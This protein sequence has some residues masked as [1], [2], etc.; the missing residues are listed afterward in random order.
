MGVEYLCQ[1]ITLLYANFLKLA[2]VRL[3]G[4]IINNCLRFE[5]L[6]IC[7]Y[8][9][10]HNLYISIISID[11]T[12]IA[13]KPPKPAKI[14]HIPPSLLPH[15]L[16]HIP[17]HPH[18]TSTIL[19]IIHLS[20]HTHIHILDFRHNLIHP[21]DYFLFI[22]TYWLHFYYYPIRVLGVFADCYY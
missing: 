9:L 3:W 7:S 22:L 17:A 2:F 18:H 11:L 16:P 10:F 6:N 20:L 15:Q 12:K 19:I 5:Q 8:F 14:P 13:N 4:W 21:I 1:F